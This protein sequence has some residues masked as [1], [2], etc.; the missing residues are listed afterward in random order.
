MI[1]PPSMLT[2]WPVIF[3][4]P[5]P[6]RKTTKDAMSEASLTRPIGISSIRSF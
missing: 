5:G 4:D 6:D 2:V 3:L 1:R